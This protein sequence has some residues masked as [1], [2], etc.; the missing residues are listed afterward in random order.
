MAAELDAGEGGGGG[1]REKAG[2]VEEEAGE[3]DP[4]A[5][6]AGVARGRGGGGRRRGGGGELGRRRA[7]L[8]RV[9]ERKQSGSG[10]GLGGP[11]LTSTGWGRGWGLDL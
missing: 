1:G 3:R 11:T 5:A 6:A 4:V 10:H 9:L 7:E 8:V 2:R